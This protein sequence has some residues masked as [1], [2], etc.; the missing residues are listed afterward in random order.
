MLEIEINIE[1]PTDSKGTNPVLNQVVEDCGVSCHTINRDTFAGNITS[2]KTNDDINTI[3]L[4]FEVHQDFT[5]NLTNPR[6]IKK[7]FNAIYNFAD[8]CNLQCPIFKS[9]KNIE[10]N[11]LHVCI[12]NTNT[13]FSMSFKA[14]TRIKGLIISSDF[15]A[16]IQQNFCDKN[17]I[18]KPYLNALNGMYADILQKKDFSIQMKNLVEKSIHNQQTGLEKRMSLEA[19]CKELTSLAISTLGKVSKTL[20]KSETNINQNV[21]FKVNQAATYIEEHYA[22]NHTQEELAKKV[23]LNLTTLASSFKK[24]HG[25]TLNKYKLKIRLEKAKTYL[26]SNEEPVVSEAANLV[27]FNNVGYFIKKFKVEF[28]KYPTEVASK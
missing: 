8:P 10:A 28:Q 27:G 6:G 12:P 20:A 9:P 26:I 7:T 1:M 25:V 2:F 4:N 24:I 5:L 19:H 23:G 14:N 22:E 15:E 3:I 11:K 13:S 16:L 18:P 17:S 21:R